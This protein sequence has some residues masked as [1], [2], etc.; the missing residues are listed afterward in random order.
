MRPDFPDFRPRAPWLGPDLQTVRN[1]LRRPS[2]SFEGVPQE[3]LVLPLSDGSGDALSVLLQRPPG[4]AKRALVVLVHGLG[5]S[6]LSAYMKVSAEH[7]LA[8]GH[9]VLRVNLRGAGPSRAICR[10]QYHAGRSEDLRDLLDVLP[11]ELRGSGV[12]L[13]GF[14]LG[15]NAVLKL[16]AELGE[17]EA[18]LAAA[19]VS[20]PIDLASASYR[21][22]D[23]RNRV[24]QWHL[25]RW[26]QREALTAGEG[27]SAGERR[28]V[29]SS[30][31]VY[32]LDDR[33][34]APRNGWE[35]ADA[36]YAACMSRQFLPAIRVPTLVI[37]ALDDPW[38]PGEPYTS[39]DWAQN[40]RL[41]PLLPR[42]GGHVG[43]HGSGDRRPWHDRCVAR[44]LDALGL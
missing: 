42:G 35:S 10:L 33:F 6:E 43:F 23:R 1:F 37:H 19:T 38:I 5:G 16:L 17:G 44:F 30:R 18:V 22:L 11:A 27:I 41:L 21:F 8:R 28:A 36:Y 24:Y 20:A 9:P 39:F 40:P 29:L 26:L 3:R 25:L 7:L 15:G 32:E 13:M 12:I 31:S 2:P 34:V 4:G 14:S